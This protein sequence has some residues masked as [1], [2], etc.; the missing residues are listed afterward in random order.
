MLP[1][2]IGI[3]PRKY[4]TMGKV[5]K[6]VPPEKM[7]IAEKNNIPRTTLYNRIR[8]GWDLDRAISEPP[9]KTVKIERDEEGTFVGANKAKPRYFSLPVELD[10]KLEKIIE[11][12]GKTPSVWLEEE[13]TKKLKR[14]KV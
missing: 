1:Y 12:S 5:G 4:G 3:I 13:M 8:A 14:M 2:L 10:E 6:L 11:K 7:A 9:R